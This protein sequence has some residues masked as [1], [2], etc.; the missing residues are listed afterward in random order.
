[1]PAPTLARPTLQPALA[2]AGAMSAATALTLWATVLVREWPRLMATGKICGTDQGMLAI[3]GHC[4]ACLPA[5]AATFMA[6]CCAVA[7][8]A[9]GRGGLAR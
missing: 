4:P 8:V 9:E 7:F 6:L 5:A 2:A 3:F 1:M